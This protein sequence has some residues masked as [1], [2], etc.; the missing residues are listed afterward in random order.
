MSVD[1][2]LR[3]HGWDVGD[4]AKALADT[5]A[6]ERSST[7]ASSEADA[8]F[9]DRYAGVPRAKALDRRV[10]AVR[11]AI[12]LT[13]EVAS[14]LRSREVAELLGCSTSRVSHRYREGSLY[15][16][17]PH[18]SQVLFPDWQ[19][20]DAQTIPH[21]TAVLAALDP[22]APAIL[23]R[24]FMERA[25]DY[26]DL[27]GPVG[28]RDWLLAGGDPTPVLDTAPNLGDQT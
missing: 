18:G 10:Q 6:G 28:P 5:L 20:E 22:D 14:S 11:H 4:V 16:F 19:F 26:L 9:L 23:V 12:S 24:R 13:S 27:G 1:D 25:T 2:V 15:G 3:S 8:A 7:L 17:N 21:L